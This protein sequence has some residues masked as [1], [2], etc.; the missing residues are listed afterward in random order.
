MPK[1]KQP[2]PKGET[3][4][5]KFK[6]LADKRLAKLLHDFKLLANLAGN[7]YK[8]SREDKH[9]V[10]SKARIA[11]EALEALYVGDKSELL[12]AFQ[13]TPKAAESDEE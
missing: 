5:Q 11:W 1:G 6:R 12:N 7:N 13:L 9:F 10:V 4:T 2:A 3:P 8:G